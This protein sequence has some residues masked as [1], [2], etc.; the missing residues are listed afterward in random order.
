M[1]SQRSLYPCGEVV[2]PVGAAQGTRHAFHLLAF[3][4]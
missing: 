1:A 4:D 3:A 2:L